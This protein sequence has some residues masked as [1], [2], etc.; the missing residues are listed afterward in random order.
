[1]STQR[2][3]LNGSIVSFAIY[4][5]FVHVVYVHSAFISRYSVPKS[6]ETESIG[7]WYAGA[8]SDQEQE[9]AD[10]YQPHADSLSK[11]RKRVYLLRHETPG[12]HNSFKKA[13]A[14]DGSEAFN[15]YGFLR[16]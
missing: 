6:T 16:G 2:K 9:R 7:S 15:A 10:A 1:M 5:L 8:F 13:Y 11:W 12:E 4:Y 14:N 3:L